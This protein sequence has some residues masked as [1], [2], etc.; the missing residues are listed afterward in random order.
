MPL[1]QST[2]PVSGHFTLDIPGEG[3][4]APSLTGRMH[5]SR[6]QRAGDEV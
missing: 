5:C 2:S 6:L 4:G 1:F 3:G